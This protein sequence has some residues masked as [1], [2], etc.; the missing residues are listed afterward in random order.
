M[1]ALTGSPPTFGG[2]QTTVAT[3][4]TMDPFSLAEAIRDLSIDDIAGLV[5]AEAEALVAACERIVTAV[6]A[7][8]SAATASL[9]KRVQRRLDDEAEEFRALTGRGRPFVAAGDDVVPS[10]LAAALR[11]APRTVA[12]RVDADCFLVNR[13]RST[14]AAYWEG[15]LE[16]HRA[17]VVT[18]HG[19]SLPDALRE[20]YEALVLESEVDIETGAVTV[21]SPRVRNMSRSALARRAA[22]IARDLDPDHARTAAEAA[23]EARTVNAWPA[24]APGMTQ[25]S[26]TLPSDASQRMWAAIDELA[27]D[28][29]R[30][31]PGLAMDAARADALADLVLANASITTTVTLLVP[32]IALSA[33]LDTPVSHTA[34]G[35]GAIVNGAP[36]RRPGAP[37]C[38]TI[39]GMVDDPRVGALLPETVAEL[40]ADPAT[41]VQLARLDPDGTIASDPRKHDPSAALRRA[42]HARDG[43]CRFPGCRTPA[44]RCDVDHVIEFPLGPSDI[45]NLATLCRRH[46]LFK[47]HGGWKT[48]LAADGVLHWST[49]D[50]RA[51]ATEPRGRQILDHLGMS[52]D[53]TATPCRPEVS[54]LEDSVAAVVELS[55]WG[56]RTPRGPASDT[57][58]PTLEWIVGREDAA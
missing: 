20:R 49:P 32:T 21:I 7:R 39:A 52:G 37:V 47:H 40:L 31:N 18:D 6:Q 23:R 1:T 17:E 55:S 8:A 53:A 27:A 35:L 58:F 34:S 19:L 26:A 11:L 36:D 54:V 12:T 10:M 5:E 25:W 43:T 41:L 2:R 4:Q 44:K 24:D 56:P 57:V 38:W 30:A 42:V 15:D 3:V 33:A 46:H 9:V 50:G 28:Y 45:Q 48:T 13:M 14:L 29:A 16:R 51:Y 22:K